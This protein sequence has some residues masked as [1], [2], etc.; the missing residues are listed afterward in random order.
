MQQTKPKFKNGQTVI[1]QGKQ[2]V[3]IDSYYKSPKE[4][5]ASNYG[6]CYNLNSPYDRQAREA[7]LSAIN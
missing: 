6:W 3:V 2:L 5:G 7:E 1:Y 4:Y